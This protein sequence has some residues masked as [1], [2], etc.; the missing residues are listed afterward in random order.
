MQDLYMEYDD[1]IIGKRS[2]FSDRFFSRDKKRNMDNALFVIK[3]ALTRYLGWSADA[4]SENLSKEIMVKMHLQP[5]MRYIEYPIEYDK[6]KDYYYLASL[7]FKEKSLGL[8]EKTIH[9]YESIISGKLSKYPKDYFVG[10]DGTVRAA[11]CL[12]YLIVH[13][14]VWSSISELYYIFAS[15]RGYDL[16]KEYKLL[17]ACRDIFETP[18]DFIHFS[19]PVAQRDPFYYQYYKFKYMCEMINENGRKRRSSKD[20]LLEVDEYDYQSIRQKL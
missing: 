17:N 4:V 15:D 9:T 16:L 6:D 14:I 5:L 19:L 7:M 13:E 20:Y 3:Y 2:G 12:Q 1:I 18:V 10:S 8:R 11:I